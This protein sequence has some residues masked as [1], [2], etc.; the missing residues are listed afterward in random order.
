[1]RLSNP[2]S[3]SLFA[4]IALVLLAGLAASQAVSFWLNWGERTTVVSQARGFNLAVRIADS[5]RILET[6]PLDKRRA[7]IASVQ[8]DDFQVTPIDEAQVAPHVPRGQIPG[9]ITQ[10]LG[11]EREIRST[12]M[13][14]G[15]GGGMGMGPGN[16]FGPGMGGMGGMHGTGR[17]Q[18]ANVA[19]GFDVRLND[20]QWMRFVALPETAA[21][22]L[23][24]DFYVNLA[25]SLII[26]V[27]VVLFAVRQATRPL[28]TLAL[29]AD[30]LGRD[31]DSAPLAETGPAEMQRAAQAFNQMQS[32]IKCLIDERA[33]ALAAVSH[34]LRTPLT[35]LRLRAELVDDDALR[36]QMAN[37]LDSMAAM[38]DATLDYL[39]GLQENEALRPIDINAL[40]QSLAADAHVLGREIA[41]AGHAVAPYRGRLTALRRALQNLIDNAIK[42]G[43]NAAV[44][45]EDDG[46]TL[47][48]IVADSGPGIDPVDLGRITEPYYRPDTARRSDT[49]GSG[50]GLSIVRDIALMHGG[51]LRLANRPEGGLAATLWLPRTVPSG[52]ATSTQSL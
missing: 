11:S 2:L 21:P 41:V 18:N 26:V 33:R 49:G 15:M 13:G 44:R 24:N 8:S 47:Q 19:R 32:R 43:R 25:L 14:G 9:A 20:G 37:D 30:K 48:L 3:G 45:I 36:E 7:T 4:R 40:L 28:Q 34:D 50:L 46:T 12:G 31:L 6:A 42:Y 38:L 17:M 27:A 22:A 52:T 10:R 35:R 23:P 29:A 16:G 1:M 39:R 5:V 51:E